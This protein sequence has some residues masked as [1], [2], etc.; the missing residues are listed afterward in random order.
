MPDSQ[1]TRSFQNS[2]LAEFNSENI[3]KFF[4][5]IIPPGW[6]R[7]WGCSENPEFD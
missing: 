2:K 6:F 1:A 4:C 3:S 7:V 5:T